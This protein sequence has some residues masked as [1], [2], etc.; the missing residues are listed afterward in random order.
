LLTAEELSILSD[1]AASLRMYGTIVEQ[2]FG[3]TGRY[4]PHRITAD[5]QQ[6]ILSYASDPPRMDNGRTQWLTVLAPR[7]TGK[8]T[9]AALAPYP[10][11]AYI[12]NT[13]A[14]LIADTAERA[15]YL[16]K[17]VMINHDNWP[18]EIRTE[19][20]S[21]NETRSLT[22][23]NGSTYRV[24][25]AHSEAVGIGQST[26]FFVGSE[27]AFWRNAERQMS[28]INPSMMNRKN[29][30][31]ILECTPAL[32]SETS[33]QFWMDHCQMAAFGGGRH[34]YAF[35]PFWDSTLNRAPWKAGEVLT[36]EEQR[37]LDRYGTYGLTPEN[38][39][40]RRLVMGNDAAVRRNPDLFAVYYPF[41]DVTCWIATGQGVIHPSV[42]QRHSQKELHPEGTPYSEFSPP[43][44][45][46]L[47]VIGVDPAGYGRD[48]SAFQVLE[49]WADEW[50]QVASY[51]AKCDPTEFEQLLFD[52]GIRYNNA[53]I[54][55]ERNNGL[56][57]ISA[58][59]TRRYPRL[60]HD[61]MS[62]PGVWKSDHEEWLA[63]LVDALLEKLV[64]RGKGTVT[65]LLG[66][67]SDKVV[68]RTLKSAILNPDDT[69][70]S[71]RERGHWDKV[72]ALMVACAVAPKMNRRYR[73]VEKPDNVVLFRDLTWDQHKKLMK[74]I[75]ESKKRP[76][77]RRAHYRRR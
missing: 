47:Y 67:R 39:A 2:E 69:S 41:D 51:G 24:L 48:H 60:W 3:E 6:T 15:S 23:K 10:R 45:D 9:T 33:G 73:T 44:P 27:V 26:D 29:S 57:T 17:R 19:K 34:L 32:L 55:I 65:Q 4:D 64:L 54:A 20:L 77:R 46:A 35:F 50:I 16:F 72:S 53:T 62:K 21:T 18:S 5:L 30:R 52:T 14:A 68:E 70:S 58:M 28:L 49:V 36:L 42:L 75:E 1:P 71:R 25:S 61:D 7:Q 63:L 76:S 56:G 43:D 13:D 66:Y 74:R 22:L 59:K 37:L 38:L 31:M 8:S 11:V 12:P 40:F